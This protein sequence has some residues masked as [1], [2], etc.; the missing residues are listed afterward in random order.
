MWQILYAKK[1]DYRADLF[2]RATKAATD[3][4][5]TNRK[6][7]LRMK[8]QQADLVIKSPKGTTSSAM[9]EMMAEARMT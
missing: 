9:M 2:A 8:L 6:L 7:L 4:Q 3:I 5:A 1:T